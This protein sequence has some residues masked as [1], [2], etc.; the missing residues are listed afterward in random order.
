MS[1]S[2]NPDVAE[3]LKEAADFD[4]VVI[5]GVSGDQNHVKVISTVDYPP[6]ILWA[7]KS[8]EM[9]LMNIGV[10]FDD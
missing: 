7:L 1:K 8:A 9:Q 5:L 3:V 2:T 10:E 4:N 6:D